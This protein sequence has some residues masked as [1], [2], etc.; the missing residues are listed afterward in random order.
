VA[1]AIGGCTPRTYPPDPAE[2]TLIAT[3]ETATPNTTPPATTGDHTDGLDDFAR[4]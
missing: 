3:Y 4:S 2:Q 1:I